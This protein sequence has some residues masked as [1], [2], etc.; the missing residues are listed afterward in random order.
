MTP[1]RARCEGNWSP[2][3]SQFSG[4]FGNRDDS[5]DG[6]VMGVHSGSRGMTGYPTILPASAELSSVADMVENLSSELSVGM[7]S[8]SSAAEV[9][10]A[11]EGRYNAG[12]VL[13][14]GASDVQSIRA[15][16]TADARAKQTRPSGPAR[17]AARV[18]TKPGDGG[19]PGSMTAGR[20][21]SEKVVESFLGQ[22]PLAGLPP[23]ADG[24]GAQ[25][26]GG[27]NLRCSPEPAPAKAGGLNA[28]A[29]VLAG[30]SWQR[31]RTHFMANLLTRVPKGAEPGVA[32]QDLLA[33]CAPSTSN[34][35]PQRS[36]PSW[37]EWWNNSGSPFPRWPSCGYRRDAGR[38]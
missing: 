35:L 36:T 9:C 26:G 2:Q 37:V 8:S 19:S 28:I 1:M 5:A 10:G 6:E 18:N 29:A 32:T 7:L 24:S 15:S 31:C 13:P 3:T 25:R 16:Q 27:G 34:C 4:S 22:P 30:A 33:W 12:T 11:D 21:H 23:F 17:R 38:V 14:P 20:F